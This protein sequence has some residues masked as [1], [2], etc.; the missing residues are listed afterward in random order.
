MINNNLLKAQTEEVKLRLNNI[1]ESILR[2]IDMALRGYALTKNQQL[3]DPYQSALTDNITNLRK[4]DSLFAVQQLDSTIQQFAPIKIGINNY[5]EHSKKMKALAEQDSIKAFVRLLNEDKGFDLWKLFSPFYTKTSRYEDSLIR[6]AID[7]YT[8]AQN[9]NVVFVIILVAVSIP[10]LL[11]L[12]RRLRNEDKARRTLIQGFEKSN[13]R[14]LFDPGTAA[15]QSADAQVIIEESIQNLKKAS[16]FIKD[17]AKGDYQ[18]RWNGLTKDNEPLNRENLVGDL[19]RMRDDMRK[20]KKNDDIRLWSTEG[21]SK[22]SEIIRNHQNE[23]DKLSNEIVRFLTKYLNAQ[24]GSLFVVRHEND[25]T[26]LELAACYA[27]EKKKYLEKR[28]EVGTGL[29]GQAYLEGGTILLK[30]LPNGYVSIT[31][32][33]G[34]AT[35]RILI[36]VPMKYNQKVEAIF[37]MATFQTLEEHQVAFLEKAGEFV[38]SAM[39]AAN[40]TEQTSRLLKQSQEQAEVLRSQEEELRQNMEE[41]QATQETI[42]RRERELKTTPDVN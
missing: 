28:I 18:V 17:I 14:F 26:Y 40:T 5:I 11:L 10:T 36:I 3:L 33:L 1:F 2:R 38:A 21:L 34:D 39:Y 30:E 20:I 7:D 22:F 23:K 19:L 25:E 35:P 29:V 8:A 27:F 12:I 13:R 15:D 9:R 24:Q 42:I 16:A 6:Q 31:S 41:M 4:L 32:G 37:E